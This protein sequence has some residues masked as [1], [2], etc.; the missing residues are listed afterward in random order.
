MNKHITSL[1]R[2]GMR[3]RDLEAVARALGANVA[4]KRA[5]GELRM[6]HHL[7]ERHITM[8]GRRRD[9]SRAAVAWVRELEG[10][11]A[12]SRATGAQRAA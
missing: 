4:Q 2:N 1:A 5:T 3:Q 7:M 9:A 8:N 12:A 11:I 10:R 6:R